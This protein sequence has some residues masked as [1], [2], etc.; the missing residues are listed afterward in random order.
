MLAP[1]CPVHRRRVLL[2]TGDITAV[3]NGTDATIVEWR[4]FCGHQGRS[5][6]PH[7]STTVSGR[8]GRLLV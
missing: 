5:R 3:H 6:F 8:A 2:D 1:H 7:R 4:C